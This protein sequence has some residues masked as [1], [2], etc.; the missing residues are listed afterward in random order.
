MKPLSDDIEAFI[1]AL[2]GEDQD[3]VDVQR[4]ELAGY[5][6][7]APSQITYVL[8]TRFTPDRGYVI[9]SR[10]GGGGFV[11]I[12][13]LKKTK[14]D[15]LLY[16]INQRIGASVSAQDAIA[17]IQQ[18]LEQGTVSEREAAL[19][20]AATSARAINLPIALKDTLRAGV[21]RE[22][23]LQVALEQKEA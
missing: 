5:F 4:N 9:E 20:R 8:S 14:A 17:M 22:M 11:R 6:R 19:M 10:R 12:V 2:L 23:L 16:L 3:Q 1:K 15:H 7:C 18:L 13:R 21:L